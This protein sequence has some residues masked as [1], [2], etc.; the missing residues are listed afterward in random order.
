MYQT[1]MQ[2]SPVLFKTRAHRHVANYELYIR[3][4]Y[5]RG[6][7]Q[8][9]LFTFLDH[10]VAMTEHSK[11]SLQKKCVHNGKHLKENDMKI[12]SQKTEVMVTGLK[13]RITP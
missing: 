9:G 13:E 11:R 8:R 6:D 4:I 12:N 10:I 5:Q 2:L 1:G 7:N 3:C